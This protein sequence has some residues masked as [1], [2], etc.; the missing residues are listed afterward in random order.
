M[1]E[2]LLIFPNGDYIE[3]IASYRKEMLD[4]N[5]SMDGCGIL[6]HTDDPLDWIKHSIRS[7]NKDTLAEGLV[8]ATQFICVR[9]SDRKIVGMIQVRHYFNDYLKEYGGNIG[10]SVRPSERNKG[11]AKWM[12]HSVL[13]FCKELGLNA[14]LVTCLEDN[15]ASCRVILSQGGRF[16]RKTYLQEEDEVL[17]RYWIQ[18]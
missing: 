16:E 4:N 10:Y 17:E 3:E 6:R 14:V 12:L 11:Y 5:S 15:E 18:L 9:K 8:L 2:L 13:P 1:E 7:T